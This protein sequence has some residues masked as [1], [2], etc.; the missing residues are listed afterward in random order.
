MNDTNQ[1]LSA[2]DIEALLPWYAA[3]TLDAQEAIHVAAALAADAE[4]VRRLDLVRA[5]MTETIVVNE[6]LGVPSA[7]AADKLFGAIDL[8]ISR[9]R[10]TARVAASGSLT[11]W[12]ADM[13]SLPRIYA[14][15]AGAAILLIVLE[16]GVIA[17]LVLQD[18]A[19]P[20]GT[21]ELASV[22]PAQIGAFAK[23]KFAPQANMTEVSRFLDGRRAEIVGGPHD[24]FYRVR[25]SGDMPLKEDLDH[26]AKEF[27]SASPLVVSAEAN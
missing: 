2:D 9:D 16:A 13:F 5:E 23:V 15:A 6:A 25:I 10:R 11:D 12:L 8:A 4:L 3:G 7:R 14:F 21:Y 27:H 26:L 19:Q 24:G 22:P 18:R 17:R 20:G 1:R